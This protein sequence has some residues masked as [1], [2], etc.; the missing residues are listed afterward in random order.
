MH[1]KA[2]S[3]TVV[4]IKTYACKECGY[5]E[6]ER[7]RP[8]CAAEGHTLITSMMKK[9]G[10]RC[11]K[12]KHHTTAI[13]KRWPGPCIKCKGDTWKDASVRRDKEVALPGSDFLARG[14]EH[15]KF[16]NSVAPPQQ[17]RPR[18]PASRSSAHW[19]AAATAP[20]RRNTGD[21]LASSLAVV[22]RGT[23]SRSSIRTL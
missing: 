2:V 3:K 8:E 7:A 6:C 19:R 18:R 17:A 14:E 13:N 16:R 22:V 9:R 12:C 1:E 11:A 20:G 15:G 21:R 23:S 10:F 5:K 4:D